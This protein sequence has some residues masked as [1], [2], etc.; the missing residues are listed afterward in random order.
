MAVEIATLADLRQ[1]KEEILTHFKE[2][3]DRIEMRKG[4]DEWFTC[5]EVQE[6]YKIKSITTVYKW[7]QPHK[8]GGKNLFRT[9]EI[10]SKLFKLNKSDV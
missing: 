9:S 5:E 1:M 4:E 2:L 8:I 3:S 7:L 6:K 10:E